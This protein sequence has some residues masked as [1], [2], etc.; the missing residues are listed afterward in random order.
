MFTHSRFICAE[1]ASFRPG[2]GPGAEWA[3]S[4]GRTSD[5]QAKF[6]QPQLW[7]QCTSEGMCL[8]ASPVDVA[9]A[10]PAS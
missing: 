9:V 2:A 8:L 3:F 10:T 6:L 7:V 4:P 1:A 5:A